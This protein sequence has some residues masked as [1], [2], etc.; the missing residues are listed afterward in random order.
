MKKMYTSAMMW[1]V[2]V[3]AAFLTLFA[4][5][6]RS[7]TV[8]AQP[9]QQLGWLPAPNPEFSA[10]RALAVDFA[11]RD[12]AIGW[13]WLSASAEL[14]TR[15]HQRL[16]HCTRFYTQQAEFN[17]TFVER[18][19]LI[20]SVYLNNGRTDPVPIRLTPNAVLTDHNIPWYLDMYESGAM[21]YQLTC[22]PK[23]LPTEMIVW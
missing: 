20:P 18:Q 9:L 4:A 21:E 16:F 5:P 23:M 3:I 11:F 10:A 17:R 14:S 22:S 19:R 1:L 13:N 7:Q 8:L 12:C 15:Y 6:L 2:L